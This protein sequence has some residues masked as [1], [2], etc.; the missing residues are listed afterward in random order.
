[1]LKTI[2]NRIIGDQNKKTIKKIQPLV[3]K[4]NEQEKKYTEEAPNR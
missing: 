3:D 4:I 1:M 2:I